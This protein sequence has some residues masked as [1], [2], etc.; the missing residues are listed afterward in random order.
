MGISNI[1]KALLFRHIVHIFALITLISVDQIFGLNFLVQNH[2]RKCFKIECDKGSSAHIFIDVTEADL[3]TAV[4]KDK[5]S[6]KYRHGG[7]NIPYHMTDKSYWN[8]KIENDREKEIRIATQDSIHHRKW[9]VYRKSKTGKLYEVV[10]KMN[11]KSHF[12]F[13]CDSDEIDSNTK[14][15]WFGF[16]N[17]HVI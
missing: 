6:Y 17:D 13:Y 3:S 4:Q 12:N 1:T 11:H 16:K 5:L 15:S 2:E 9:E 7:N 14:K 8:G 10:Q